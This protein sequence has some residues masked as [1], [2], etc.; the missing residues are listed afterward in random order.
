MHRPLFMHIVGALERR[1]LYFRT[2]ED[3][4]GKPGVTPLQKCTVVIRQLAYGGAADMF[5]EYL[6][7][8]ESTAVEC[9]QNF[10]AGLRAIFGERY[11]RSPSPEDCQRLI[12]MHGSVHGFPGM[13]GSIDYDQASARTKE[14]IPCD[15]QEAARKDV[16]RAFGVLQSRWAVVKGPSRQWYIPNIGDVMY[17]CIIMH[18]MIVENE[19]AK[20]TQWTNEDDTGAGPR[21]GVAT[22]NVNMGV[23]HGEVKRM[24]AFTDMRQTDSHVRL[25]HDIIEEV[26]TRRG[27]H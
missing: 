15:R 18:N 13:L 26:W 1:Y 4:V 21:H 14:D 27:G 25:Q 20:L 7:I 19:A 12:D 8:G 11:L 2:W 5:D 3:A 24:R 16:E 22:A 17:A 9:L 6:H 23:P 10:C